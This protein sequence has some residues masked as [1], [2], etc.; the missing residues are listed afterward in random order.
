MLRLLSRGLRSCPESACQ[1]NQDFN[2][3]QLGRAQRIKDALMRKVRF[4]DGCWI[5]QAE[6][7]YAGTPILRLGGGA[8]DA[9][10]A[11]YSAWRGAYPPP[12]LKRC[13]NG[14]CVSPNCRIE[15]N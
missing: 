14:L 11:V 5:W 13:A 7:N 15:R 3:G 6:C 8:V 4:Q 12:G 2:S 10:D 1:V 9:A